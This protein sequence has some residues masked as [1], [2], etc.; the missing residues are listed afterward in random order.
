MDSVGRALAKIVRHR[1]QDPLF[2]CMEESD[3]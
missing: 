2:E 1:R 3:Q